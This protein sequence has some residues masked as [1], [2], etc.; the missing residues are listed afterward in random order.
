MKVFS[1]VDPDTY[2]V[3][4]GGYVKMRRH[5][6]CLTIPYGQIPEQAKRF[7]PEIEEE[8]MGF[9]RDKFPARP[10][11]ICGKPFHATAV[12]WYCSPECSKE[13][14]RRNN[15]ASAERIMRQEK[16]CQYCGKTYTGTGRK[17]CSDTCQKAATAIKQRETVGKKKNKK[18][19][20]QLDKKLKLAEAKGT[21]YAEMQKQ[22]TL[23]MVGKVVI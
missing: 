7:K 20:S 2:Y 1:K 9:Y 5:G 14:N 10:C 11:K 3:I 13:A 17:Y 19:K 22:E 15:R 21:T 23:K 16:Q 6:D 8:L 12:R 18:R 4:V